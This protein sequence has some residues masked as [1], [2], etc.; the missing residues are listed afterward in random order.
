[1]QKT[2]W[3]FTPLGFW[4]SV[5]AGIWVKAFF[6]RLNVTGFGICMPCTGFPL[7]D[8]YVFLFALHSMKYTNICKSVGFNV[9]KIWL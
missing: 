2:P 4:A 7:L 9:S 8:S 6:K 1:M 3:V 5:F